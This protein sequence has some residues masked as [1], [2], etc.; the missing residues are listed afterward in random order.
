MW[1][2]AMEKP[3]ERFIHNINEAYVINFPPVSSGES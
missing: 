1:Q 3:N 2:S